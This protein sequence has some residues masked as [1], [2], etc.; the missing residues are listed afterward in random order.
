MSKLDWNWQWSETYHNQTVRLDLVYPETFVDRGS[1][2]R[3][4][5]LQLT[6]CVRPHQT[7]NMYYVGSWI[8]CRRRRSSPNGLWV[9]NW[10]KWNRW[11]TNPTRLNYGLNKPHKVHNLYSTHS[12]IRCPSSTVRW[13]WKYLLK[14]EACESLIKPNNC[15]LRSTTMV[16]KTEN[17]YKITKE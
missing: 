14:R 3:K 2:L 8:P 7:V 6:Q 12:F 11:T 10:N 4:K 13:C 17:N 9:I 1:G 16:V 5:L 15:L